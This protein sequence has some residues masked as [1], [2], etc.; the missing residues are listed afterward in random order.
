MSRA[1]DSAGKQAL[2][3]LIA[4]DLDTNGLSDT[5]FPCLDG[6]QRVIDGW[7]PIRAGSSAPERP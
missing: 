4:R 7:F 3:S 2:A 5:G 1:V 6:V